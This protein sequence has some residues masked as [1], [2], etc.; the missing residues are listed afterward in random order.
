MT[1]LIAELAASHGPQLRR[2]LLARVPTPQTCPAWQG[3]QE[4]V[5]GASTRD[6][7]SLT[8]TARH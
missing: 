5:T 2:F 3:Q 4:D 6:N 7:P 1:I 8:V